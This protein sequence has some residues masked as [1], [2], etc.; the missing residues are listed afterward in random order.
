MAN[1][2]I[3]HKYTADPTALIYSDTVYL[4]TGHDQSPEGVDDYV[5]K[6]WL[7]FSSR[8]MMEWT[9]YPS[10]LKAT[11]FDWA[12][13]DAFASKVIEY[14]GR[15]YWFAAVSH[16]DNSGK[17]IGLAVSDHPSGPFQDAIG[18]ALISHDMLPATGNKNANLDPSVLIDD[19]SAYIFWGHTQCYFA[20]LKGD[21]TGLESEVAK[22]DLPFFSEGVH[23]HKR[24]GIYYLSYGY[25]H[26]EK[27]AYAMS[28]AITG[29]WQFKGIINDL[30]FNCE[31]NRPAIVEFR[32]KTYFFY[33]NG[34][35]PEGG[36]HRRSVCVEHL[37]YHPDD[38]IRPILMTIEGITSIL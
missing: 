6:E 29:P 27:V 12:K 13:G 10:P 20:K 24:H 30:A 38:T 33:H 4:Y 32:G 26:P 25:G 23:I 1:P 31:T 36:S 14:R 34:A 17:A 2:I 19:G 16:A 11:D 28:G 9:E 21:L 8:D 35:L 22:I 15:F 18:K 5:M 37:Q 7:C 3:R